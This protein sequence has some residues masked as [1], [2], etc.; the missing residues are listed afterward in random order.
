VNIRNNV[1]LTFDSDIG[2]VVR[3]T[4]P[5]GDTTL[6]EARARAAMEDMID[7]GIIVTTNGVPVAVRGAEIVTTQR[8]PLVP[9][10]G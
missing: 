10:A 7:D 4:I 1:I 3:L 2:E 9:T 5:R 8:G 6:T